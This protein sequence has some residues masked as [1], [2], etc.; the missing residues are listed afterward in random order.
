MK[1]GLSGDHLAIAWQYPGQQRVVIPAMFSRLRLTM[2]E[3]QQ[4]PMVCT[5]KRIVH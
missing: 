4:T 2:V 1:E 5:W 3:V